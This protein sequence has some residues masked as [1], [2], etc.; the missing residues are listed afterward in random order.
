MR[1]RIVAAA[2]RVL[3]DEGALGFTTTR[4]ADEAGISVGSMYQ[5]FPTESN[6][7]REFGGVFDQAEIFLRSTLAH[8]E[9]EPLALEQFV[10]KEPSTPATT[11]TYCFTFRQTRSTAW[12]G[13][14][15]PRRPNR[16]PLAGRDDLVAI[17]LA[18]G[19]DAPFSPSR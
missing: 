11:A 17:H 8:P 6:E 5:Y 1:D 2:I 13:S 9:L 15:R 16:L 19:A 3:A 12:H 4:V 18:V 14:F 7:A 10:F